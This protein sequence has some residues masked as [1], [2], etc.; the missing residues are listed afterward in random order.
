MPDIWAIY[1]RV[2][3]DEQ[4][5]N[6]SLDTQIAAMQALVA[7]KGGVVPPELVFREDFTGMVADRP[8][9]DRLRDLAHA[10]TFAH[11]AVFSTDR[12][13]RDMDTAN[14]LHY[15]LEKMAK[16]DIE[17][18][19][20]PLPEGDIG[21]AMRGLYSFSAAEE[22]KAF[23]ERS[24]RGRRARVAAGKALHAGKVTYGYQRVGERKVPHDPEVWIVRRI[25]A[26]LDT[27]R[28]LRQVA[29]GLTQ[30]RVPTPT[31]KSLI[32]RRSCVREIAQNPIYWGE[33]TAFRWESSRDEQYARHTRRRDPAAVVPLSDPAPA[34]VEKEQALRVAARM[35]WNKAHSGRPAKEPAAVLLR[36][37]VFCMH[38]ERSMRV[39]REHGNYYYASRPSEK[40]CVSHEISAKV[41]DAAIWERV[42][43]LL[44]D[45]QVI[46]QELE[47]RKGDDPY[48]RDI[49]THTAALGSAQKQIE[50]TA[51]AMGMVEDP[52]PLVANLE[53][54]QQQKRGHERELSRL[55]G[56]QTAWAAGQSAIDE[57]T[58]WLGRVG[59][60]LAGMD[61]DRRR[62]TLVA[63]G[64]R[65]SVGKFGSSPR[66]SARLTVGK[67]D[68]YSKPFAQR[69]TSS[70]APGGTSTVVVSC[71][72]IAGP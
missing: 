57:L 41:L 47:K 51:R 30:D 65:V 52:S 42:T 11:L 38:C 58:E 16:V 12:L 24:A 49:A 69:S 66:W 7:R 23:A 17:Y 46:Q 15:D 2:S 43:E 37:H 33:E 32:W 70:S 39:K 20:H 14:F 10:K 26:E 1:A 54:L 36:G 53:R 45:P 60:N 21:K 9:M 13:A 48:A 29:D 22:K 28:S 25:Y 6:C 67:S 72:T 34:L 56:A 5:Y 63:L 55:R 31:G 18:V 8:E 3:T 4:G 35:A 50:N 19:Q 40:D 62:A 44:T 68:Q 59:A 61:Y 64:L 71:S 27:G